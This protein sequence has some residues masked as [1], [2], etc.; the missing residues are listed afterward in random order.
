MLTLLPLL[1][2]V[3]LAAVEGDGTCPLGFAPVD[4]GFCYRD[5]GTATDETQ[6]RASCLAIGARLPVLTTQTDVDQ[7][8]RSQGRNMN[9]WQGRSRGGGGRNSSSPIQITRGTLMIFGFVLAP[10][11]PRPNPRYTLDTW[12]IDS[13]RESRS[14][15]Q[16]SAKSVTGG[17]GATGMGRCPPPPFSVPE[18]GVFWGLFLP[19]D[20][21]DSSGVFSD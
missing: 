2:T 1:F 19:P 18:K 8:S 11:P 14:R 21:L 20:R 17:G 3:A 4:G 16:S 12:S 13:N 6:A 9:A 5:L 15:F 10:P 7:V